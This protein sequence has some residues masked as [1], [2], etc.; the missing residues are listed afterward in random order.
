[1]ADDDATDEGP[2]EVP[3]QEPS[4]EDKA[5]STEQAARGERITADAAS[6][7]QS[8]EWL[9]SQANNLYGGD[10]SDGT[11]SG[12]SSELN[13]VAAAATTAQDGLADGIFAKSAFQSVRYWASHAAGVAATAESSASPT[14]RQG[15]ASDVAE[16]VANALSALHGV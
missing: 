5:H 7:R 10:I 15:N 1:M 14:E 13:S 8:L 16:A 6:L 12:L 11:F 2:I 9:Y 3:Y 4:E